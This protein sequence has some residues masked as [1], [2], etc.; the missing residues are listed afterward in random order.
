MFSGCFCGD[1]P[2]GCEHKE[3]AILET[4]LESKAADLS[5]HPEGAT[6]TPPFL[7]G[8][9]S[10]STGHS[11]L[12]MNSADTSTERIQVIKKNPVNIIPG[13]QESTQKLDTETQDCE[14]AT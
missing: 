12:H 4:V 11:H 8:I 10:T 5:M 3:S 6:E 14:K 2:P 1:L 7:W 13:G 9:N